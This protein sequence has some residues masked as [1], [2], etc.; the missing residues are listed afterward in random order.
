MNISSP[1]I[2]IRGYTASDKTACLEAFSS[3][4]P[5]YFLPKELSEFNEWLCMQTAPTGKPDEICQYYVVER[6]RLVIGCGGFALDR[7]RNEARM[8]WGLIHNKDHRLGLGRALLLWR[9]QEIHKIAPNCTIALDTTQHAAPF[10]EKMG[11]TTL[12]ITN[13]FYGQGMHR[14]DMVKTTS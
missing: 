2:S 7:T 5:R 6:N 10:F 8:T 13:D 4:I 12:K 3:N 14:Y 11:F 1:Q 9:I